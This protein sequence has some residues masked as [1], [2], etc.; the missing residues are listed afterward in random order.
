[1]TAGFYDDDAF[2]ELWKNTEAMKNLQKMINDTMAPALEA[3]KQSAAITEAQKQ[4]AEAMRPAIDASTIHAMRAISVAMPV[5][6]LPKMPSLDFGNIT[7][8][9][10]GDSIARQF[11][12]SLDFAEITKS[13]AQPTGQTAATVPELDPSSITEEELDKYVEVAFLTHPDLAERLESDPELTSLNDYQKKMMCWLLGIMVAFSLVALHGWGTVDENVAKTV[14][15][16]EKAG[17]GYAA[18]KYLS[19]PKRKDDEED[20]EQKPE[21]RPNNE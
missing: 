1:M 16:I 17:G 19:K 7:Q 15:A 12:A 11:T 14:D 8:L 21:D 9:T 5:I 3:I 4:I 20:P 18:Y 6:E 10:L 13:F 2:R